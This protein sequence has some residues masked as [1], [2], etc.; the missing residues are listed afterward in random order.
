[1]SFFLVDESSKSLKS[2]PARS[3]SKRNDV[4]DHPNKEEAD[5]S[6][7]EDDTDVIVDDLDESE[8]P[9]LSLEASRSGIGNEKE[10]SSDDEDAG[11][12]SQVY[13]K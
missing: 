9:N 13:N 10:G 8:K 6:E 5:D 1:M 3:F 7:F 2:P 4:T 12:F 11:E